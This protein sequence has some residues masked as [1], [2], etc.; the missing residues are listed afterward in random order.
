MLLSGMNGTSVT[1]AVNV[2][3]SD[4]F[5]GYDI[6]VKVDPA[7]LR[8]AGTDIT[9]IVFPATSTFVL[10]NRINATT[11]EVRVAIVSTAG[12]TAAPTTGRLFAVTY[13]VV[14]GT[15]SAINFP[16]H[17]PGSSND[18]FCVTVVNPAHTPLLVPENLQ[19]ATFGIVSPD[20]SIDASPGSLQVAQG[21]SANSTIILASLNGFNGT[22]DLLAAPACLSPLCPFWYV[23]PRSVALVPDGTALATLTFVTNGVTALGVWN[24]TVTGMSG[25]LAHKVTA[26]FDVVSPQPDF[27]IIVD[28]PHFPVEQGHSAYTSLLFQSQNEFNGTV[29]ISSEVSR[30]GLGISLPANLIVSP[31]G[32][33]TILIVTTDPETALGTYFVNVTGTSRALS[34]SVSISILVTVPATGLVCIASASMS[35]C[36]DKPSVFTGNVGSILTVSV[37]VQ[38]SDVINSFDITLQTDPNI[39]R[40]VSVDLSR[41]LVQNIYLSVNG[42]DPAMGVVHAVAAGREF[43]SIPP[44]TGRLFTATYDIIGRTVNSTVG[45]APCGS[46]GIFCVELANPTRYSLGPNPVNVQQASFS[47]PPPDYAISATAG[48]LT[49]VKGRPGSFSITVTSLYGFSGNVT[50]SAAITPTVRKTPTL[51]L[52][53]TGLVLGP[54]GTATA[55]LTVSTLNSTPAGTYTVTLS[56]TSG[57]L[58]HTVTMT[59]IIVRH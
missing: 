34:H 29:N 16:A 36:P 18:S 21:S 7:V 23:S 13:T 41:S 44:T 30:A 54:G 45:F 47:N 10:L 50:L 5:N 26:S 33:G 8:P 15:G 32:N 14:G 17:C 48:S 19:T 52:N 56:V 1:V 22:V 6:S 28:H 43:F 46:N 24:V 53:P 27:N 55:T 25:N 37:N 38:G 12:P 3:D 39:L 35:S 9:G 49:L 57:S 58:T 11:G 42:T 51:A 31:R 4:S 59:L 20:F 40:P 2:Q